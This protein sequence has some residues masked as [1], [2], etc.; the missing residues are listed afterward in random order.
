MLYVA[1]LILISRHEDLKTLTDQLRGRWLPIC[2]P[3]SLDE[4]R[5]AQLVITVTSLLVGH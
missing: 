3:A 2:I 5:R 4:I 1:E